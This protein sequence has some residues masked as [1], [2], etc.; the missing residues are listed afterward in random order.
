MKRTRN[1]R[2]FGLVHCYRDVIQSPA[3][4]VDVLQTLAIESRLYRGGSMSRFGCQVVDGV[5]V[6]AISQRVASSSACPCGLC[7]GCR[8]FAATGRGS[9]GICRCATYAAT[10]NC[11]SGLGAISTNPASPQGLAIKSIASN[12]AR[13]IKPLVCA[14]LVSA[15]LVACRYA[16]YSNFAIAQRSQ[17]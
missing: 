8:A 15:P 17:K 11:C 2:D 3:F 9:S 14:L 12:K 4:V 10:A 6:A 5:A 1:N 7:K 16:F 13:A